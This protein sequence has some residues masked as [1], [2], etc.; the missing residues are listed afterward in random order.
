MRSN[1]D[2]FLLEILKS[3]FDTIADD[4]ALN[5]MRTAYSGIVRDSMDFSTAILDHRGQTLAQGLTTPMHLGSFYDAM[6]GLM[7]HF[8]GR[9]APGDVYIFNDPYVARRHAPAGHLHR[10]ADLLRGQAGWLGLLARP[11]LRRR[12]HRRRL[13]CALRP[14][15][16]PG[17]SA[18]PLCEVHRGRQAR[19]GHLGHGGHQ[20]AAARQ[21]DGRSAVPARRLRDG[22][23][24]ADRRSSGA[25][26]LRPSWNTTT[27]FTTT[28]SAWPAPRSAPSPTAPTTSPTTSTGSATSPRM[29]IF[30]LALT[31]DGDHVTA[32]F[33]GSSPQVKGGINA[34]LPFIKAS[35]YAALRSI[36]PE[37]VPN[38]H[39]YTRAITVS[40]A[41]GQ[42]GQSRHAGRLW[43][44]RHHR[45]P[46]HR[47]HVRCAGPGAARAGRR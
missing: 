38:C 32:D 11:S 35:V 45:L 16:L 44:P 37:E 19:A 46:H 29:S 25:M 14:R 31:V 15:D 39:G 33:A 2:P 8:E 23:A 24:R 4:M 10:Q 7:R 43:R 42:R 17:G 21:G 30:Q 34:P 3:S 20:R 5:L 40:R 12:R 22:R 13:Q 47:L 27:I 36:M 1:V 26:A 28:R 9:M 18:H 41:R 6:S